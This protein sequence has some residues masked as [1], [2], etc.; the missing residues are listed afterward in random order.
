M[1]KNSKLQNIVNQSIF[2]S[3]GHIGSKVDLDNF[4]LYAKYNADFLN[5]FPQLIFSFNGVAELIKECHKISDFIDTP[6]EVSIAQNL[7]HTFGTFLLDYNIFE[8]A[9]KY[10]YKY[11]WKFSN[12]VIVNKDIFET[13]I[14]S[15]IDFYYTNNIGF[16]EFRFQTP[17]ELLKNIVD[18]NYYYPQ[19]NH[20]IIKN[21]AT[22]HPPKEMILQLKQ[23]FDSIRKEK[24]DIAPWHAIRGCDCE[25]MLMQTVEK[26]NFSKQY[27]LTKKDTELL[28]NFIHTN[29]IHD[30]SHKNIMFRSLG[31]LCHL[32]F[33][34]H[35]VYAI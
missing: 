29:Q 2:G 9:K 24:P 35:S 6:M 15:D 19:T 17:E 8:L 14:T 23:E 16:N 7:G 27:L 12:D 13:Q 1:I 10:S 26:N 33:P 28:I 20:Y 31:N 4:I 5:S 25:S 21:S 32:Q 22:F 18:Q 11:L 3:I 34:N 30:G